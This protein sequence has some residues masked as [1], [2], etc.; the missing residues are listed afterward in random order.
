MV[1]I[2][3]QFAVKHLRTRLLILRAQER[4]SHNF[5]RQQLLDEQ[6]LIDPLRSQLFVILSATYTTPTSTHS[7]KGTRYVCC[8]VRQTGEWLP[9]M[10]RCCTGFSKHLSLGARMR[11][12]YAIK[13]Q[14]EQAGG[15]ASRVCKR[16]APPNI[17]A[18]PS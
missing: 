10:I 5:Q 11:R 9:N 8:L 4:G 2:S 12:D 17:L 6:E 16:N 1:V 14:R 15:R 18:H 3:C 13:A 7:A